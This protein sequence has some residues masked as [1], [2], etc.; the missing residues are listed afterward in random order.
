MD[1]LRQLWPVSDARYAA[2]TA[3]HAVLSYFYTL[4]RKIQFLWSAHES[5]GLQG[6][7]CESLS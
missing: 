7:Y 4:C 1:G 2:T 5:L 6:A 3:I